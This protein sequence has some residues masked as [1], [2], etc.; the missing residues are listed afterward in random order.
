MRHLD[1]DID[2]ASQ[3]HPDA[4]PH[5]EETGSPEDRPIETIL[6]I[7]DVAST[8]RQPFDY[9]TLGDPALAA[10]ARA[11]IARIRTRIQSSILEIGRELIAIKSRMEHGTFG[12][13]IAAELNINI[14]TAENYMN[15]ATFAEGKSESISFLPPSTLYALAAPSA[16]PEVVKE[17]LAAADTGIPMP[18]AEIRRKL[19]ASAGA[20][21][22]QQTVKSA[23]QIEQEFDKE[24]LSWS[25]DM[26][27]RRVD[28]EENVAST[29]TKRD[30]AA[31]SIAQLLVTEL[32]ES[33]LAQLLSLLDETDWD[34][35]K[36]YLVACA[37]RA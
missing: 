6:S 37:S 16:P 15:A 25:A 28:T 17:V 30:A 4:Y 14:R 27:Q 33:G 10:D 26:A 2:A 9:A 20:R 36:G 3:N 11:A 23:G 35:V 24:M 5:Q 18:V 34:C 19:N 31:V 21:R 32:S 8:N 13:W 22:K 1:T 12:K 29:E 7:K